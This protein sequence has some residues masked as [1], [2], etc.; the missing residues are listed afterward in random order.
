MD[1]WMDVG[2][3]MVFNLMSDVIQIS[4]TEIVN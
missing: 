1:G 2:E 3:D 4:L